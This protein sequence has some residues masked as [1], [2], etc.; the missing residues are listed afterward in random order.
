MSLEQAIHERWASDFVLTAGLPVERVFT[1]NACGD[2]PLP[3]AVLERRENQ[4]L[5]RTSSG[6]SID[7]AVLRITVWTADLGQGQQILRA[8]AGRFD[9]AEF[10]LAA[11]R[12]LNMERLAESQSQQDDGAWRLEMDYAVIHRRN[13]RA[14]SKP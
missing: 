13:A 9:R 4:V 7:R 11:G 12:V 8:V 1:G 2:P 14:T 6:T 3:Y 5:A 10:D